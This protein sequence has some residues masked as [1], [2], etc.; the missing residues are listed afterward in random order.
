MVP[1][2]SSMNNLLRDCYQGKDAAIMEL[3]TLLLRQ[4]KTLLLLLFPVLLFGQVELI[5]RSKELTLYPRLKRQ[6]REILHEGVGA[7]AYPGAQVLVAHKGEIV[8]HEA[9]GFHTYDSLRRVQTSDIYDLASITKTSSALLVLMQQYEQEWLD[10]DAGL[11]T[12]F[13][14]F[15]GTEKADISLRNVLAHQG[16]L[17]PWV[18]YWQ[19]T[20]RANA[21]YPWQDGWRSSIV[22]DYRF[23][24]KTLRTTP[25]KRYSVKLTDSLYLHRRFRERVIYKTI[26]KT[27]L[28]AEAKYKYSGLLFYLLPDYVERATGQDYRSYLRENFYDPLGANTLG[29]RPLD[30]GFTLDKII[31]TER[32][33]FFRMQLLHGVVHDEGAAMMDGISANAGLF[34]NAQD[35][36]KLW[37]MLLNGGQYG[38]RQYFKPETVA[39]FIRVQFPDNDNRRGLGF[40]KPLLEYDEQ[41]SSVAKMAS[42]LSFGHSGYTGTLVWADPENEILFIFLSNRV[43]PSRLSRGIYQL[44]IRPR[45]MN[46]VYER[47]LEEE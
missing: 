46:L 39:T 8:L 21:R 5:D 13:P 31:P 20:L 45:I 22:N 18:P 43:Y 17:R 3:I 9:V 36:A 1:Y 6:V 35:L 10:L 42:P 7:K 41:L 40:D 15:A 11:A 28:E 2:L 47:L 34:S 30:R 26:K 14:L 29:Y 37:Q 25:N 44:N 32:D 38:G 27:P 33:T 4:S 23:R 12:Y 19:G 24:S 16:R